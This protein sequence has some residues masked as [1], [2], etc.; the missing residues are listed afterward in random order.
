MSEKLKPLQRSWNRARSRKAKIRVLSALI[1]YGFRRLRRIYEVALRKSPPRLS[2]SLGTYSHFEK[3]RG[4]GVTFTMPDLSCKIVLAEKILDA[5][6]HRVAGVVLHEIGHVA[7]SILPEDYIQYLSYESGRQV[8]GKQYAE[9]RAD[10]LGPMI[11]DLYGDTAIRYDKDTV[12]TI[13]PGGRR[14]A[15][16]G[17]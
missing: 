17:W 7:D 4:Y 6:W 2:W 14:P 3:D 1:G 12:Q 16:L 8:P 15:Y 10:V 5:P 13:G 9:L 11:I